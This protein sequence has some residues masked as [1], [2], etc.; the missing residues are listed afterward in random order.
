M[1]ISTKPSSTAL[2]LSLAVS[3]LL[4]AAFAAQADMKF[5]T[6]VVMIQY[7]DNIPGTAVSA[8]T[9]NPKY[10]NSPDRVVFAAIPEIPANTRNDYGTRITGVLFPQIQESFYLIMASDDQGELHLSSNTNAAN[11]VLVAREPEW[12]NPRAWSATDRR[13]ATAKIDPAQPAPNVS[14]PIVFDPA[15]PRYFELLAKEGG[16]GDNLAMTIN[17]E[18]SPTPAPPD[19]TAPDFTNF[20]LGVW[21]D[22][23]PKVLSGP[24]LKTGSAAAGQET[25]LTAVYYAP[26]G[27]TTTY[28][29][30]RNGTAIGGATSAE[31][32]FT[33]AAGDENANYR[34]QITVDGK[35][36]QSPDVALKFDAFSAGF[37]KVE[38]FNDIG[39]T[40][41]ASLINSAKYQ[42][43]TP[44][45]IRFVAGAA[46]PTDTAD[47]YG[48]R[49]SFMVIPLTNGNYRFFIRSDDAS[50]FFLST[51]GNLDVTTATM[52]AQETACCGA[53]M[54]VGNPE[55]SEPQALIAGETNL[56][57]GLV[58]EG[59]GGDFLQIA[60]REETDTT[61]AANL[62][63][64]SGLVMGV[65]A[66]ATGVGFSIAQHPQSVTITEERNVTFEARG[67]ATPVGTPVLYRWQRNGVDIPGATSSRLTLSNVQLAEN[68]T[69]YRA[70][71]S[72]I[73]GLSQ[74]T[75]EAVLTVVPDTFPPQPR[76]AAL[77]TAGGEFQISVT[78]D[79]QVQDEGASNPVHYAVSPGTIAS[80][81]YWTNAQ[82]AILSLSGVS[83]GQTIS[84]TV[85]N[86]SDLKNNR[87]TTPVTRTVTLANLLSW[88]GIGED[89]FNRQR[90]T[91]LFS[92]GAVARGTK[93]FDLI[94]G[95]DAHWGNYDEATFVYEQVTGDFDR[96]VRVEYQDPTS[97][98]A[99]TGLMIREA[100][101]TGVTHDQ[102]TAGYRM[103]QSYTIRV[104]PVTQH[105]GA[106]GNN[107]YELI[108]RPIEGGVYDPAGYPP[109]YNIL[110]GF[111]GAPNYPTAWMRLKRIGQVIEAYKS[112]DGFTW[113]GPATVTY[114]NDPATVEQDESLAATVYIGMFYAPEMANNDT[115]N[116]FGRSGIA[117]FRD[118]GP[119]GGG[120]GPDLTI[121]RSG[122]S[123]TLSW[124]GE[125]TLQEAPNITGPWTDSLSQANP[126]TF[127]AFHAFLDGAQ[128]GGGGRTG[129]GVGTLALNTA[130]NTVNVNVTFSGLS[131]NTTAAH[132]HGP[133]PRGTSVGVLY[134]LTLIPQ[135]QTSGA[136]SQ[137]VTLAAGTGGFTI[138][139]QL[140]Q[141]RTG[142][143]YINIHS[144][145]Q[146]SGGEIRGQIEPRG[147]KFF[148]IRQASP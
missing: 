142:Q 45:E 69:R 63:P 107:S 74:T 128:D 48:A 1:N 141:L 72:T 25:T 82:A 85:S 49:M 41:V 7:Y 8:L 24:R 33:P 90:S 92:D 34:V 118:Y 91:D 86:I 79:E 32:T 146:F 140:N 99:R 80:F 97:Q 137:T 95:G 54:D 136:I 147:M 23:V 129:S 10:P 38:F 67:V 94:S 104:N 53:F 51:D 44:D 138:A 96:A 106:A 115:A 29:W 13:P 114:T 20:G 57:F 22:D 21:A 70:V 105:N 64:I 100:L 68:N 9:G 56:F 126:Q 73:G 103:S 135:G 109:M 93:D 132:I 6:N 61:A 134:P 87:I 102:V 19:G 89:T 39:N 145:G 127:E 31:Y 117:K 28:Q 37:A 4:A 65:M 119:F 5:Y 76:V 30:F 55:T 81:K 46:S 113:V 124:T 133:A 139:D 43:N 71:I 52:L 98:W 121:T 77:V 26:P 16:G 101:D 18:L 59:G 15:V 123:V 108:H 78:F 148:R 2:R 3:L 36:G 75:T 84:V 122:N 62:R 144:V 60:M 111:G 35:S 83:A 112:D 110:S 58:K 120:G 11:K 143:W 131:A 50:Q 14:V 12:N 17:P 27:T 66:N 130:N 40:D 116:G 42:A 88:T 125:G 47:N